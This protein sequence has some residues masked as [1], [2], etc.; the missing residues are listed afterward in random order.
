MKKTRKE[1]WVLQ[2]AT[3]DS[4]LGI[5]S[6]ENSARRMMRTL[7]ILKQDDTSP[8]SRFGSTVFKC[9]NEG[10]RLTR[11]W[12]EEEEQT[13]ELPVEKKKKATK[14]DYPNTEWWPG[15]DSKGIHQ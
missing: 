11:T 13:P 6:S 9:I 4:I 1:V 5:Y 12:I 14:T 15:K 8:L 7:V 3:S 10:F 2:N